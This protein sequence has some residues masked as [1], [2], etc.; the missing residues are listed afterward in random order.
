MIGPFWKMLSED[1]EVRG[2]GQG[3]GVAE[4]VAAADA[5]LAVDAA[6]VGVYG[7]LAD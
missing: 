4:A 2:R 3:E 1:D 5:E 7:A 6:E